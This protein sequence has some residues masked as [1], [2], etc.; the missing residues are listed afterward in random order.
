MTH[1]ETFYKSQLEILRSELVVLKKKLNLSSILRLVIFFVIIGCFYF[2]W[3][4]T[5]VMA[6]AVLISIV[7]FVYLITRHSELQYQRDLIQAQIVIN[8]TELKVLARDFYDLPD[9]ENYKDAQH[10]YSLDIDLFGRGSF[11][12]YIN[13]TGLQA[14]ADVLAGLLTAN[15]IHDITRKQ[16]AIKELCALPEWRQRFTATARLVHAQ[17]PATTVVQWLGNYVSF[18][19]SKTKWVSRI[20]SGISLLVFIAFMTSL[21]AGWWVFVVFGVGLL[22]N[23]R[24]AKSINALAAQTGKIQSTFTQYAQLL[25]EIEEQ[26][27][28]SVSLAQERNHII[29][30][31][32]SS[33]SIL[34]KFS[35]YLDA[36]DQRNNVLVGIFANGFFLRDWSIA[37]DIEKWIRTHKSEVAI[38]FE[39]IAFFDAYNSLGNYAYNHDNHQY[40]EITTE[41]KAIRADAAAHPLLDPKIAVRND[42]KIEQEQFFIITGANMAGKSTFLRT[43]ALHIVMAN[44]GLPVC[45][46]S[47]SYYPTKL[48]T[49]MRTTDSLTDDESYFFSELKRLKYI[50]DEIKTER[51]FIILDEILKGTN[52]TDKAIGS[53]KFVDKLVASGATGIIAT[54]DLSLCEAANDLD[55]VKNYY[56]DARIVDDE[57]LFDY[58]FK[59]GICQNMNASFLLKKMQIVE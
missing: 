58:T 47:A 18:L 5:V 11:Y 8:E 30:A 24:F 15:D 56:F 49:S 45:A 32:R 35:R 46:A 22:L 43:V 37:S 14:G 28:K 19:P 41:V 34:K 48:I 44:M 9:G 21:I 3:G 26:D 29:N 20:F 38:W 54:H 50:V 55:A 27:F 42:F 12:Q 39:T 16:D 1:P 6:P 33:S 59:K 13:R 57:L 52:S 40:P 36:F 4:N 51:Y 2:L 17:T 53:R 23:A 31:E 7:G 25:K 10:Y